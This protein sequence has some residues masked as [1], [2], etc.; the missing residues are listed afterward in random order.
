MC[1]RGSSLILL[2]KVLDMVRDVT[3]V[4]SQSVFLRKIVYIRKAKNKFRKL[5]YLET[6]STFLDTAVPMLMLMTV[7]FSVVN[8][9]HETKTPGNGS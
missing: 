2:S 4:W 5:K 8:W 3:N 7:C 6:S 1:I 9:S